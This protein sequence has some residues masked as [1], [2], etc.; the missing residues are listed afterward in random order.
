MARMEE[1]MQGVR[2]Q[3]VEKRNKKI[4]I[5]DFMSTINFE[6]IK[7]NNIQTDELMQNPDCLKKLTYTDV[8]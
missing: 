3:I 7:A 1:A 2:K 5:E 4:K 8:L 6:A